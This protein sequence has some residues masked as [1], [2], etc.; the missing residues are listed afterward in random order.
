MPRMFPDLCVNTLYLTHAIFLEVEELHRFQ[1]AKVTL[2]V[3]QGHW[4]QLAFH[5]NYVSYYGRAA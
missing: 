2:K 1:M 4:H 3:T 5:C